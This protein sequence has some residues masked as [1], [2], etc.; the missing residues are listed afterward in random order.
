M[1][2]YVIGG[3]VCLANHLTL[4]AVATL[5]RARK[6]LFFP[7]VKGETEATLEAMGQRSFEDLTPLYV[8]GARDYDNYNRVAAKVVAEAR[9][10]GD[11][12]LLLPGHPRVGVSTV[13]IL[14][15]KAVAAG[16]RVKT[17]VGVSSFDTMINDLE[18]DPLEE[19]S[20]ILDANRLLVNQ[21][22]LEPRVNTFIYHVCSVGTS[23]TNRNDPLR[24]NRLDLLK[25]VLLRHYPADHECVLIGSP[26]HFSVP[27]TRVRVQIGRFEELAPHVH[28]GTTLF[29]PAVAAAAVDDELLQNLQRA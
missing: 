8:E 9:V 27:G 21:Y 7:S 10:G 17:L 23:A 12:V 2:I 15:K 14:E 18:V 19:G 24:G 1:T 28:F 20:V 16:F 4:E 26:A 29:V 6:V 3:G 25:E 11:V 22:V 13:K 5:A